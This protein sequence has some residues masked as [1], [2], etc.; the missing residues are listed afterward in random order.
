MTTDFTKFVLSENFYLQGDLTNVHTGDFNGD[1]KTD[2]LRQEKGSWDDDA[3]NTANVFFSNGNGTFFVSTLPESFSLKGDLTNLYPGDFNGDGKTDFLRQEKGSWD[4]DSYNTANVFLSNGYGGFGNYTL[5]E[6]F[7]LSGDLTNVYTGDFNGDGNTDFLRQEKGY[8]DDDAYNTANVFLSNGYGGFSKSVL[9]EDFYL[10]GDLTNVYTGDFNGDGKT[11]FLRQEKGYWDDDAYNTANV[12]LSNGY[13][14]FSK[15]VLPEDFYL[16]GD[17]TNLYTEDFNGDGK[18]DFL[19]QEKGYWDDD[20]YN[21]ANVFLSNG[22]GGFSKSVLPE[23]FNLSGD[24]T[25]LYTGDFN[26]DSQADFLRQEKGVW[27]D[28]YYNTANIFFASTSTSVA[29]SDPLI[30]T[31]DE[32]PV[33]GDSSDE[34]IDG[35][36]PE[37]SLTGT[38]NSD[39]FNVSPEFKTI[40]ADFQDGQDFLKLDGGLTPDSISILPQGSD[41]WITAQDQTPLAVLTGVSNTLIDASDFV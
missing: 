4:D 24:L 22:Y 1:G 16:S 37:I 23:N 31:F 38:A 7:Y 32:T 17:L 5:P 41:T 25:N 40:I 18:T 27:D 3:N 9:P 11:D 39:I 8:W 10:Q 21:T 33:V 28:D 30:G 15:S 35:G 36:Q 14:G 13:G 2:F 6:D 12:F 34:L 20:A 19:R 26:G 29:I